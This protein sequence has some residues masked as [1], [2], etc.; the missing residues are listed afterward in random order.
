MI[1][2][3]GGDLRWRFFTIAS[4]IAP[5]LVIDYDDKA[6]R[7]FA[8]HAAYVFTGREMYAARIAEI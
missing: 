3:T 1:S 6:G 5:T 4:A 2:A 8:H 7:V